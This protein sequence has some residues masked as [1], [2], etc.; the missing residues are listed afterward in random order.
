L[1]QNKIVCR[2]SVGQKGIEE[3]EMIDHRDWRVFIIK[4]K[5][6]IGTNICNNLHACNCHECPDPKAWGRPAFLTS[7]QSNS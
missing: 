1:V 3:V 7:K 5:K 4:S 6:V 2:I